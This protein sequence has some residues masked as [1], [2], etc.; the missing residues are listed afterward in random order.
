MYLKNVINQELC[1]GKLNQ[2]LHVYVLIHLL[3]E[4]I[5]IGIHTFT[6]PLENI[7][8]NTITQFYTHENKTIRL[9]YSS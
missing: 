3:V 2:L 7:N 8:L 9:F 6:I 1:V 5:Y 4:Y